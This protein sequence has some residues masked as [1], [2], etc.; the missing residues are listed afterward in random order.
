[1]SLKLKDF[2]N[3]VEAQA[4]EMAAGKN[5]QSKGVVNIPVAGGFIQIAVGFV[6]GDHHG[7]IAS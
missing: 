4:R 1:M 2:I 7:Q 6:K 3:S 5:R